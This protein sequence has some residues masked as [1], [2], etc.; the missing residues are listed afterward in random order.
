MNWNIKK[1]LIFYPCLILGILIPGY[2]W[3]PGPV[4]SRN[5][6]RARR[7]LGRVKK[8]LENDPR[9]SQVRMGVSTVNLGRGIFV[10]GNVPDQESLNYLKSLMAQSISGKFKV[11]YVVQIDGIP[12]LPDP[13]EGTGHNQ[14]LEISDI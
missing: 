11:A 9:F 4:Q 2:I 5:M 7:E 13:N 6:R 12:V 1:R 14:P 3:G 8:Q 10:L